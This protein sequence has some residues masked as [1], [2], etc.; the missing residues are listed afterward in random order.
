MSILNREGV[1]I[2]YEVDGVGSDRPPILLTHGYSATSEM[3]RSNLEALSARRRVITWDIRGHGRSDSPEDQ[4]L[5]SSELSVADMEAILD[6]TG[7]QKALVGGLSLGG[8]LSLAFHLRHPERVAA[9]MLFDTGP[10]FKR[11]EPRD[12]WNRTAEAT[13]AAYEAR[14]LEALP[15]RPEVGRATHRGAAGLAK[16]ARGILAQYDA[17]VIE[18]LS[19]IAVPVLV[20]VGA[21]DSPFLA[22][23]DYMASKVPG[24]LKAVIPDAGH[25]S[26]IDQPEAFNRIVLDFLDR[27]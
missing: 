12:A 13:A 3:W 1:N 15:N 21:L 8:Y 16:A 22:A 19:S 14:G 18:S 27:V 7:T 25:A 23:S 9:L 6:V 11:D 20:V 24:A 4:S 5:Y 17:R 2:F 10:G 26:N